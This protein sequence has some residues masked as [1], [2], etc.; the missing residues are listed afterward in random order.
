MNQPVNVIP[1]MYNVLKFLPERVSVVEAKSN[2][3][4]ALGPKV[5]LLPAKRS[6]L[7]MIS[8]KLGR[9]LRSSQ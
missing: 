7:T 9:L 3:I 4:A 5:A 2:C 1:N 8:D 6:N